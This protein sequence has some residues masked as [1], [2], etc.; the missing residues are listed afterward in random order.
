MPT[1]SALPMKTTFGVL[2]T[3]TRLSNGLSSP[4][5]RLATMGMPSMRI[6]GDSPSSENAQNR[7]QRAQC[8]VIVS[9]VRER[10]IILVILLKWALFSQHPP[11]VQENS[12]EAAYPIAY[13]QVLTD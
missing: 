6:I 2:R 5:N 10:A 1:I 13:F 4:L 7:T 8:S 12:R 9:H 3:L 11:A